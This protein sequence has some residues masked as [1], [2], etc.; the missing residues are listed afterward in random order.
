MQAQGVAASWAPANAQQQPSNIAPLSCRQ[1]V[2]CAPASGRVT[3]AAGP[4]VE[5]MPNGWP[6]LCTC[7]CALVSSKTP[8]GY[9]PAPHTLPAILSAHS[10]SHP[11]S[12]HSE[13]DK[14]DKVDPV[15]RRNL[16]KDAI[17]CH[18]QYHCDEEVLRADRLV[19]GHRLQRRALQLGL[20]L[21]GRQR[22]RR[23]R[24][25]G[26][27]QAQGGLELR[28]ADCTVGRG[29]RGGSAV[30]KERRVG[31]PAHRA[32][33]RCWLVPARACEPG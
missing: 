18:D 29:A 9:P 7:S 2:T 10:P 8:A 32:S 16:P 5:C 20:R 1:L 28:L 24:R 23:R 11:S 27:S 19:A 3:S 30:S 13:A 4:G 33:Q 26:G 15:E 31:R 21:V 17:H 25:L 12:E 14:Q 22:P 6:G